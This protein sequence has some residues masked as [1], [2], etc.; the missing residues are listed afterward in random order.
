VGIATDST[1]RIIVVDDVLDTVQV[2]SSTGVREFFFAGAG[3]GGGGAAF[4]TPDGIAVDSN[5]R[6]LVV[7]FEDNIVQVYSSTGAFVFSFTG[8]GVGGGGTAWT[9]PNS[10][11]VDS[12]NLIMQ[13][14]LDQLKS[15]LLQEH[16]FFPLLVL[17]L[18]V[19]VLHGL[20]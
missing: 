5:N 9:E 11:A 16:L 17:V 4:A 7:D 3:V 2:Y 6:I 18:T 19:V 1:N 10:I 20:N 13:L 8:T 15:I 14:L 12:N